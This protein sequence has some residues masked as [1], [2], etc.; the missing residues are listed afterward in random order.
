ME[1]ENVGTDFYSALG[2]ATPD[3]RKF[4]TKWRYKYTK[5]VTFTSGLL[6]YRNN[7]DGNKTAGTTR[8]WKPELSAAIKKPFASRP[9]SFADLSYKFD[10]KY[11]GGTSA[12]DHYLNLNYR[13]RFAGLDSDSNLGYTM[14]NT[15]TGVRDANEVNFNTALNSRHETGALVL[16]PSVNLGTWYSKDE[17][18]DETDKLYEYSLGLGVDAPEVKLTGDLRFGQNILQKSAVNTDNSAKFF[19]SLGAYWRPKLLA[20]FNDSTLFLRAGFNDYAFSTASRNF[21]E[22]SVTAGLN[23]SF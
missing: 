9:D 16:K 13:D 6:W 14:Y 23:V 22:K 3:R 10:R 15:K 17:L 18:A 21:R 8:N 4:K 2:A 20:K 12:F 5:Q 11:G 1:Y 19:A 7:L